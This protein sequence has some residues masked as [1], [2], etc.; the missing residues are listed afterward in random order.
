[1]KILIVADNAS[2][3][4]S[5]EAAL[6]L[7]YFDRFRERGHEVFL[8][9]HAR[10]RDELKGRYEATVYQCIHFV[11]DSVLQKALYAF[12]HALPFIIKDRIIGQL[13]YLLT[14]LRARALAKRLVKDHGV[15]MVFQPTPISSITP[16]AMF[17]VGVPVAIGPMC[18]GMEFPPAFTYLESRFSRLSSKFGRL[19]ANLLNRL[20]PGKLHADILLVANTR[21]KNSLPSGCRGHVYEVVESGVD[22]RIWRPRPLLPAL[23]KPVRIVYMARFVDQKGIPYLVEAFEQVAKKTNAVLELIG[24]GELY[25]ATKQQVS[26]LGLESRVNFHGWLPLTD[27]ERLIRECDIY[28]VPAIRDCGGCAMLEAMAIGL[29]VIAAN[30]AGPGQ[31]ADS[32]CGIVVDVKT[33][34]Q[35]VQG[36]ADAM[37]RLSNSA[38]LRQQLGEGSKVRV[39]T[40]YLDWDAKVD[41]VLEIFEANIVTKKTNAN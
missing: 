10:C 17:R 18:G 27:A 40:N 41:R 28:M 26:Q 2:L 37:I 9:S 8:I 36:L 11:E 21:T 14:Q 22:L 25:E 19:A 4:F 23:D 7:Y 15:E 3:N 24:N 13:I 38:E 33:H 12:G 29:P 39:K 35:F 1:M 6:P 32:T 34:E 20:I 30:W 31:Y 5:G 16:S